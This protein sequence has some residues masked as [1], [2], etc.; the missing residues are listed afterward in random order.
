[1]SFAKN[2][3]WRPLF[4]T[5]QSPLGSVAACL[6]GLSDGTPHI[7]DHRTKNELKSVTPM[8]IIA[9]SIIAQNKFHKSK[10]PLHSIAYR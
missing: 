1:M 8:V 4:F 9:T 5:T 6:R 3:F 7:I 10:G 2:V